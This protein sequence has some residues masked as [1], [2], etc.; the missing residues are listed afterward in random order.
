MAG[1]DAEK[2]A[3]SQTPVEEA[4]RQIALAEIPKANDRI[5][6]ARIAGRPAF[7]AASSHKQCE[8]AVRAIGATLGFVS[9]RP[10]TD[11][12]K[13]PDNLWLDA[14]SKQIIA[15]ELKTDKSSDSSL[16]KDDIGQ[17]HN[18]LEW[19]KTQ[20]SDIELLGLI[21]LTEAQKVSD[22]A[23]PS[24]QM[25]FG[26]PSNLNKLWDD[27][28]TAIDRI[29]TLSPIEKVVEANKVGTL[30]EWSPAGIFHR[31]VSKKC[32]L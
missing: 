28:F 2:N 5:A 15:F 3:P 32:K 10:C 21:F 14:H 20:Y 1:H 29:K 17:G 31:L 16:S 9:S 4:I 19:V 13:G 18:H 25:Y 8:E 27:F 26:A 24:D 30:P 12:G 22:K 11:N 23:D 7:L 6:K